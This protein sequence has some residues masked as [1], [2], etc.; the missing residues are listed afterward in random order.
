M[1]GLEKNF[2]STEKF[3]LVHGQIRKGIETKHDSEKKVFLKN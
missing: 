1:K 2:L 3:F